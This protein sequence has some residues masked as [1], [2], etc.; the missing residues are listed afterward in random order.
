MRRLLGV[1]RS[2]G[3]AERAPQPQLA[4]V[5]GPGRRGPARRGRGRADASRRLGALC[6][7]S[8]GLCAYRIVQEALSN[9]GRHAP[10]AAVM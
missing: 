10:G 9:A 1:L 3:P 2:D 6:P 4:D 8:V 5:A 7:P